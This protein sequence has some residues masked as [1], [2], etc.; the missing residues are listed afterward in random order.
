M[1][2][3]PLGTTY[4]KGLLGIDQKQIV[5]KQVEMAAAERSA[6]MDRIASED[7]AAIEADQELMTHVKD[8]GHALFASN[9]AACHGAKATGGKGF[10]NLA[11]KAWLWG[12]EPE[13]IAET[14]TMGINSTNDDTRT[15][16]MMALGREGSLNAE[17]IRNVVAFVQSLSTGGKSEAANADEIKAG[18]EVF[19]ANCVAC[20]GEDAKGKSDVG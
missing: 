1:P 18:Q 2:A 11:A 17:Q 19:A 9:C 7:F 16:Q 13:T 14:I 15:S 5:T 20:H 4:T 8:T 3:F 10:P 12:G 6:W